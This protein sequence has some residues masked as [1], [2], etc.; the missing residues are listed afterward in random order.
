MQLIGHEKEK[1]IIYTALLSATRRNKAL[2]H[3]LFSGSAGCGKTTLAKEVAK[4]ANVP[5]FVISPDNLGKPSDVIEKLKLL[6]RENY[7]DFGNR[8][9]PISAPIIFIDEIHR[10][11]LGGQEVLGIAMEEFELAMDKER[12]NM[13][14]PYFTVIGATTDDGKL[15]KPYRDRFKI[16][17]LFEPYSFDDSIKIIRM[18]SV[19]LG[20]ILTPKAVRSVA[21]KGRGVPRIIVGYLERIRDKCHTEN[22]L[23]ATSRVV[24][25]VF[26]ELEIDATGLSAVE[27]KILN[28]LY[29][30]EDPIGQDNLSILVNESPKTLSNSIEPFL[31]QRGLIIRSGKGRK[32]TNTGREYLEEHGHIKDKER[33]KYLIEPGY[34][35]T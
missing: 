5:M 24:D 16:R 20:I 18:H 31:I 4:T 33:P 1:K 7:D 19:R 30:S 25:D 3:L 15:S 2:P 17:F 28:A 14:L 29:H 8:I 21:Q 11:A 6:P 13:W 35:R 32:I 12:K 34:V 23:C 26:T 9:G 22:L 27:L 10:Q